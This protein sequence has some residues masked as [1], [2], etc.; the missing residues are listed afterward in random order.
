MD[1]VF[2]VPTKII[3]ARGCVKKNAP[4]FPKHGKKALI[5]TYPV[6]RQNGS[7]S[8]TE[9]AL[10]SQGIK[11]HTCMDAPMNPRLDEMKQL[12]DL[13]AE[14]GA[15]MVIGIGGGSALDA[16]KTAAVLATNRIQPEELYAGKFEN[17]PLDVITIPTTAGSGSEVTPYAV[18]TIKEKNIKKSFGDEEL[19]SPA[20]A[21]LDAAYS[22]TMPPQVSAD[23][24]VDALSH[25]VEGFLSKKGNWISDMVGNT[26]FKNFA[27]CIPSLKAGKY[28]FEDREKLLFNAALSG[29]MINHMRTLAV[30]AMGYSLTMNRGLSHGA[31]CGILLGEFLEY[32]YDESKDKVD[33]MLQS[34][35]IKDI[36]GFKALID[37]LLKQKKDYTK[38]E[39][40]QFTDESLEAASAKPNPRDVDREAVIKIYSRSLMR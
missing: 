37:E 34:L 33:E 38:E 31:A 29:I 3:M 18:L 19:M 10:Q 6:S 27:E 35:S 36:A 22:E 7:L 9:Q 17:R 5:M 23:T 25:A 16:A 15:D 1:L 13:A 40:E 39:I 8:D 32:I 24:A 26:I 4:L 12:G 20:Y 2:Y 30:H 11:W 14:V 21:L 28:S